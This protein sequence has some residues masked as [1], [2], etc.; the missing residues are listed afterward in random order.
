LYFIK[1]IKKILENKKFWSNSNIFKEF[2]E[3]IKTN[4][5]KLLEKADSVI[6][7]EEFKSSIP[8]PLR[9]KCDVIRKNLEDEKFL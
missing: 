4:L 6:D 7:Y 9:A 8:K 2:G 5:L 3:E 1:S